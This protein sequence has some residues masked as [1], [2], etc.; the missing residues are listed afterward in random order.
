MNEIFDDYAKI[1]MDKGLVK[2]SAPKKKDK[3]DIRGVDLEA[4][5]M[6]Y[7]IKPNGKDLASIIEQA[8]PEPVIIA[9]SYDRL[10]GL[11]EN[12]QERQ[13]A[14][15]EIALKPNNGKL[16]QHRYVKANQELLHEVIK[17]AFLMDSHNEEKLMKLADS[18]MERIHKEAI[19]GT[20][21]LGLGVLTWA[22]ISLV[23]NFGDQ[24]DQG[25][26]LNSERALDRLQSLRDD[27]PEQ[28]DTI[29]RLMDDISTVKSLNEELTSINLSAHDKDATAKANQAKQKLSSYVSAVHLLSKRIRKFLAFASSMEEAKGEHT[30]L[31]EYLGNYG[32]SLERIWQSV[33]GSD[34]EQTVD[35]LNTLN[36]SLNK[37]LSSMR[38]LF[39]KAFESAQEGDEKSLAQLLKEPLSEEPEMGGENL[40][41]ANLA[42]LTKQ[43]QNQP[44]S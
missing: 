41:E 39:N 16:T 11:V 8:H 13:D 22:T 6:L 28:D 43:L 19:L 26:S 18:C 31:S 34:V 5:Q 24:L 40:P 33:A 42:E 37:S 17:A 15:I 3:E 21:L 27:W 7:G 36:S 14:M 25:V 12:I 32:A 29:D 9:P 44:V 35:I 30:W 20:V 38:S 1:M 4:I 2:D 23:Q 10:N